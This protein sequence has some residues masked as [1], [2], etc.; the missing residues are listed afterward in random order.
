M[1]E[2]EAGVRGAR[3]S[4]ALPLTPKNSLSTYGVSLIA[5]VP[6]P[7]TGYSYTTGKKVKVTHNNNIINKHN[8]QKIHI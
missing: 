4:G 6:V 7:G 5:R 8:T 3:T 2:G 1:G